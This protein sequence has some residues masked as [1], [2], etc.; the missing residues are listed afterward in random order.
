MIP[1]TPF[2]TVLMPFSVGL[3]NFEKLSFI[4][5]MGNIKLLPT[6]ML[7]KDGQSLY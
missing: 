3:Q 4:T 1:A 2:K 5:A 6:L 7:C